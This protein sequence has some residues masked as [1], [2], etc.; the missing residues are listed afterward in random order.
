MVNQSIQ[1]TFEIAKNLM[2]QFAKNDFLIDADN[3][4]CVMRICDKKYKLNSCHIIINL[5]FEEVRITLENQAD[6]SLDC[7]KAILDHRE[8]GCEDFREFFHVNPYG[9]LERIMKLGE[10]YF[11]V[12]GTV[13]RFI[14]AYYIA[15]GK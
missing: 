2:K 13:R 6:G 9:A 3:E 14:K 5:D 4:E 12:E 8:E 7:W 15:V 10:V 1:S 11:D